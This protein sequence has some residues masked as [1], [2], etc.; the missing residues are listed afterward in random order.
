[1]KYQCSYVSSSQFS[2]NP[3]SD[4][5]K[6]G[7]FVSDIS[8]LSYSPLK[9]VLRSNKTLRG[10][11]MVSAKTGAEALFTLRE[12]EMDNEGDIVSWNFEP[13][14][15]TVQDREALRYVT[16]TIFND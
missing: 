3:S 2:W 4:D 6:S 7:C 12:T 16:C 9:L 15:S 11:V 5:L 8:D 14:F 13:A 1:M 10:F